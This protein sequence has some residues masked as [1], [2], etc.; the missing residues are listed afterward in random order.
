MSAK[1]AFYSVLFFEPRKVKNGDATD[2]VFWRVAATRRHSLT[3]CSD[4]F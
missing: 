4:P 2:A 1:H 3:E